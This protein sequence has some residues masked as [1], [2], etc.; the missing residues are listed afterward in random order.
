MDAI[1]I[2]SIQG[3]YFF[4][5]KEFV[6]TPPS[7]LNFNPFQKHISTVVQW[8]Q[9]LINNYNESNLDSSLAAIIQ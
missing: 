2:S 6:N 9:L 7:P 3:K 1:L 5:H 4:S 8:K